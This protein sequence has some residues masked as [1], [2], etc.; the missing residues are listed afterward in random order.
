[1][2]PAFF[3]FLLTKDTLAL[4]YVLGAITRTR[5]FHPLVNTHTE[6]TSVE[7]GSLPAQNP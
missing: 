6:R 4:G 1:L 5:D 7:P 2:P 3:R